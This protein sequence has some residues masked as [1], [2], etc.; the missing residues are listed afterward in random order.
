[1]ENNRYCGTVVNRGSSSRISDWG[2]KFLKNL[3]VEWEG[4]VPCYFLSHKCCLEVAVLY[5]KIISLGFRI[6]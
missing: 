4:V 2:S 1:M 6:F 5:G 3:P